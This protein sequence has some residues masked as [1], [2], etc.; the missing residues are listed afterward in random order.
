MEITTSDMSDRVPEYRHVILHLE[1]ILKDNWT[2]AL[3]LL[4]LIPLFLS[5]SLEHQCPLP[6]GKGTHIFGDDR[7][8]KQ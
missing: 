3:D 1:S 8:T 6:S 7:K 5:Y 2:V 4:S